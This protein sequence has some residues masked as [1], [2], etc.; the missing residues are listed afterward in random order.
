MTRSCN[1]CDESV[2]ESEYADHLRRAHGEELSPIDRRRVGE[3]AD[4]PAE[5][6]YV[7]YAGAGVLLALFLVGYVVLFVGFGADGPSAVVQPDADNPVHEH[8]TIVVEHD[9]ETVDFDDPR[10]T[11][12][13]ECFHFHA[14]DNAEV[15]HTHCEDVTVEY[16][17]SSLGMVVTE[18]SLVVDGVE[19]HDDDP[20]TT[21]SVTVNGEPVDPQEYVLNGV[22]PV[23]DA[24]NGDGDEV[25]VVAET[26][27]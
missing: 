24:M 18:E 22:G 21:V 23:E 25:R 19:Y 13:D 14:A 11:F 12:R 17:L 4:D 8:G 16:A 1:Y 20:N 7:L 9:G 27:D 5:R 6:N 26:T 3:P 10:Y 2:R 15:W